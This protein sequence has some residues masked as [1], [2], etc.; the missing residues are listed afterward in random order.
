MKVKTKWVKG[1]S[2]DEYNERCDKLAN[3]ARKGLSTEILDKPVQNV[4]TKIGR[5]KN[6]VICL[7]HGTVLKIIDLENNIVENYNR[8]AHGKRGSLIE[9]RGEKER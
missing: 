2:G 6:D 9:I 7:W 5:K 8:E 4:D 1:H 3:N